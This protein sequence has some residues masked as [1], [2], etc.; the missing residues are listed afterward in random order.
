MMGNAMDN[1]TGNA[2]DNTMDNTM[3]NA[4]GNAMDNTMDN[5]TSSTFR[6]IVADSPKN[7]VI[8]TRFD[9]GATLASGQTFAFRED[10][11]GFWGIVD[12]RPVRIKKPG[13]EGEGAGGEGEGAGADGSAYEIICREDDA[14]FWRNYFDLESSYDLLLKDFIY[15]DD[16]RDGAAAD[17]HDDAASGSRDDAASDVRDDAASDVRDAGKAFLSACVKAFGGLRLLRQPVWESVCAFIISA[18]NNIK[19]IESIYMRLSERYGDALTWAGHNFCR[20]PTPRQLAAADVQSLQAA[21]LGYRAPY[22]F[23]TA[24]VIHKYG[25]PDLDALDYDRALKELQKLKGVGEKVADCVLLFSTR[26]RIAFPVDVWM[27]RVLNMHYGMDGTRAQI[28]RN[29]QALFG[30]AAGVAQQFLFHGMRTNL[31]I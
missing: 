5:A 10:G 29:A 30:D 4:T 18:N 22:I 13:G 19:R 14:C 25:L 3:D 9:I 26:H 8:Y 24:N 23:E 6:Q 27:E 11:G 16:R 20:F 28:K 1:A 31:K 7:A 12:G 17:A 21:G 15:N 2:M